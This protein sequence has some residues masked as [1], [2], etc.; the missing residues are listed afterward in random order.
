MEEL[1]TG[2]LI[3]PTR[4][5]RT[6][7]YGIVRLE[8]RL[9]ESL[10]DSSESIVLS[11]KRAGRSGKLVAIVRET[12]PSRHIGDLFRNIFPETPQ[13][14]ERIVLG[15]GRLFF[16]DECVGLKPTDGRPTDWLDPHALYR[17]HFQT[18]TL[19]F[20]PTTTESTS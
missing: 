11:K 5:R 7:R 9:A 1:G 10:Y 16:E 13:V 4:E 17:A 12:R 18:V 8:T 19:F 20:E 15:E 6:D 14:G 2:I 3:W